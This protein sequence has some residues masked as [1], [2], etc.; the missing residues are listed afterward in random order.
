M[1]NFNERF[2]LQNNFAIRRFLY[3]LI[4]HFKELKKNISPLV[5]EKSGQDDNFLNDSQLMNITRF[6]FFNYIK[7]IQTQDVLK[8]I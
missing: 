5:C 7:N 4:G 2:T 1:S 8:I 6:L 3:S